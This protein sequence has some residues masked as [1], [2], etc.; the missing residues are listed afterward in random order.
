MCRVC[1]AFGASAGAVGLVSLEIRQAVETQG[2]DYRRKPWEK[3]VH[4]SS[5]PN[6]H[7]GLPSLSGAFSLP[8]LWEGL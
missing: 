3:W 1:D 8:T 5:E 7:Q 6:E 2:L 4:P